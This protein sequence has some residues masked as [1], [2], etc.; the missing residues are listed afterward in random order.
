MTDVDTNDIKAGKYELVALQWDEILSKPG[1]P[2]NF[3]RHKQGE[4]LDLNVEDARRL[5]K[6]GAVVKPGAR[7]KAQAQLALAN[8]RAALEQL[9]P[10]QREE[11]LAEAKGEDSTPPRK[12]AAKKAAAKDAGT[13]SAAGDGPPPA[14]PTRPADDADDA[15]WVAYATALGEDVPEGADKAAVVAQMEEAGLLIE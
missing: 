12:R 6:A 10:E 7:Q 9:T 11:V 3:K 4:V 13:A 14:K 1:E 2:F 15:A 5:V 8:F